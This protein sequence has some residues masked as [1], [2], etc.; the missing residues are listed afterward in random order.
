[1]SKLRELVV[2]VYGDGAVY[3]ASSSE[4]AGN[5]R[6]WLSLRLEH[7]PHQLFRAKVPEKLAAD[8]EKQGI[9]G[10]QVF[11]DGYRAMNA[12]APYLKDEPFYEYEG[13][14]H[15]NVDE[16]EGSPSMP[17]GTSRG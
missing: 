15:R 6:Y 5:P 16:D 7:E 9:H 1:M 3:G 8:L 14:P 10:E 12:V 4:H 2:A 11:D 13:D 17:P